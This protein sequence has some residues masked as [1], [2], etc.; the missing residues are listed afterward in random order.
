MRDR[1]GDTDA[2]MAAVDTLFPDTSWRERQTLRRFVLP[3]LQTL[4]ADRDA[5][6]GRLLPFRTSLAGATN[7][8]DSLKRRLE[9]IPDGE[10]LTE[11]IFN[12]VPD[13]GGRLWRTKLLNSGS[14]AIPDID[15]AATIRTDDIDAAHRTGLAGII[16]YF[17]VPSMG[18][19]LDVAAAHIPDAFAVTAWM[20]TYTPQPFPG[21]IDNETA[22]KGRDIFADSCAACHGTYDDDLETPR[23]MSF[24]NWE[25]NVG[26]DPRRA[27]LLTAEVADA[28]NEG[29]FGRYI[30]ART[31]AGYTAPPLTGIWASAPYLH[32]GSVPTLWHL[33][34]PED[35]PKLFVVGGHALDLD[36]V[37]LEGV[38]DGQGGWIPTV[39]PW[40]I[41]AEIDTGTF[42]LSNEGHEVGFEDLSD[43]AKDALLE[44]LKLL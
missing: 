34:R 10:V 41:P 2:M 36:R 35:R 6:L 28:V 30:A 16:A 4:V 1:A 33:M 8:L 12:S 29:A 37:G 38:D 40:S 17:T 26:T 44:Y 14:Y 32:N 18:V 42:G 13:L 21:S 31:V 24:P 39:E 5:A 3:E 7:G 20:Q 19:S 25:G 22:A 9:L 11:S 27:E 15:H 43:E 23:L